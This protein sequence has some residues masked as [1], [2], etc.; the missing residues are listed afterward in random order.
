MEQ[1][2]P[3]T[4]SFRPMGHDA[5]RAENSS[6]KEASRVAGRQDEQK[7]TLNWFLSYLRFVKKTACHFSTVSAA[8][9]LAADKFAFG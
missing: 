2:G 6:K 4:T 3:R 7:C 8:K 1:K 5:E 9:P